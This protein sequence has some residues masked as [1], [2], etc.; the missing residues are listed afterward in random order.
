MFIAQEVALELVATIRPL[1]PVI[2]RHDRDLADQLR[3]ASTSVVLNLAEG[4][5]SAK[6]NKQKHFAIAHGSAGE[7]RAALRAAV[8]WGWIDEKAAAPAILDRLHALLWRLT[9]PR[10]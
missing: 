2:E 7:V 1:M 9:H 6:G 3:R 5:K 10:T 8:A 4:A